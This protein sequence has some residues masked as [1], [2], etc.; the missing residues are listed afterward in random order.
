MAILPAKRPANRSALRANHYFFYF[1]PY[2]V[3]RLRH[4]QQTVNG[5]FPHNP[6]I[7]VVDLLYAVLWKRVSTLQSCISL[8]VLTIIEPTI[9]ESM[10][11][12]SGWQVNESQSSLSTGVEKNIFVCEAEVLSKQS[13]VGI[14]QHIRNHICSG[15]SGSPYEG[16]LVDSL[17]QSNPATADYPEGLICTTLSLPALQR[18]DAR[19]GDWRSVDNECSECSNNIRRVCS[20]NATP[21]QDGA[22]SIDMQLPRAEIERFKFRYGDGHLVPPEFY[23]N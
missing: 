2:Q 6:A 7:T 8:A 15:D 1:Q 4:L 14:A 9:V 19:Y 22:L 23:E 12:D 5:L 10:M 13:P 20:I 16:W 18:I 11:I 3:N 17:P 21:Q